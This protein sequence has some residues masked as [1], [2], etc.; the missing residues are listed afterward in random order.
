MSDEPACRFTCPVSPSTNNLYRGKRWK[1]AD[2]ASWQAMAGWS[3]KIQKPVPVA[4]RVRVLI[5]APF[6]QTR[7]LDNIKPILD[8]AQSLGIIEND[9]QV[10][11]LTIRRVRLDSPMTVS[12]WPM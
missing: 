5:E 10:D 11:E 7:D 6:N 2:Y 4:G 1:T 9:N 3:V 12:I 8:L